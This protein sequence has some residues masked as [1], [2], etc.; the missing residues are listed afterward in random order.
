LETD[1]EHDL[2]SALTQMR[3]D[4]RGVHRD[5][6][7]LLARDGAAWH[8]VGVC[9]GGQSA[10]WELA[11]FVGRGVTRSAISK[12]NGLR[13]VEVVGQ[14]E[15]ALGEALEAVALAWVHPDYH[16]QVDDG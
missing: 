7:R 9:P 12:S 15:D 6:R 16:S 4:G 14:G 13:E 3:G 10:V 11:A 5:V 8:L 1:L 2:A